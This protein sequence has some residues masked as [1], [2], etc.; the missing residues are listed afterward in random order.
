LVLDPVIV[1]AAEPVIVP[2]LEPVMV[3]ALDPVI[4]PTRFVRDPVIVPANEAVDSERTK[5]VAAM[6]FVRFM[7]SPGE[8]NCLLGLRGWGWELSKVYLH[9]RLQIACYALSLF[10]PHAT[11]SAIGGWSTKPSFYNIL[12]AEVTS[13]KVLNMR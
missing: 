3:P 4:V 11:T 13:W 7:V 1:P 8:I 6:T 5:A 2:A 10:K 9:S 12:H